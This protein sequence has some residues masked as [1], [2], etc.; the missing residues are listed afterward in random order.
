MA[1]LG[2][3]AR[4]AVGLLAGALLL[5]ACAA[6]AAPNPASD[7]APVAGGGRT[8]VVDGGQVT[9]RVSWA[10]PSAGPVFDVTLDTHA[11]DLDGYDLTGLATLRL[12]DGRQVAP[13]SW[14][15][16]RGG[17]HRIG[18]LAFPATT[19][20]GKAVLAGPG[21]VELVIR[22]VAG[23]PERAFEWTL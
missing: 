23:V 17:H 10:G 1:T 8:Q 4:W 3:A 7:P 16:P 2:R 20:D 9:V 6:P 19:P 11:V 13:T 12:G 21:P 5:G 15:A 18:K 14:E 22:D